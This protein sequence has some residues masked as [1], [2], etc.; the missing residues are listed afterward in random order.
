VLVVDDGSDEPVSLERIKSEMT[1]EKPLVVLQNEK[2][3]GITAA[4]NKGLAWISENTNAKYIARLDCGDICHPERF[5]IQV[6]YMND[7]QDVGLIGSWCSIIDKE[8]SFSY[9]YKTST[10]H[11]DICKEMY[12]RN[13]FMHATVMFRTSL[14][15]KTGYYPLNFEYAEDYAFFWM[16]IKTSQSFVHNKFLVICELNKEGLSYQNRGKQLKARWRVVKT[17]GT[18]K[19]MRFNAFIRLLLLFFLPKRLLL[20]LKKMKG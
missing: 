14:L 19:L 4:L 2:N 1:A 6:Q 9:S 7:H 17:F 5:T 20:R 13:V 3:T 10:Q 18:N 16:L 8:I 11:V 15:K 12:Y